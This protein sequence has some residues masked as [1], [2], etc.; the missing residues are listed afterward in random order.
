MSESVSATPAE[1]DVPS[2]YEDISREVIRLRARRKAIARNMESAARIPSLTADMQMDLSALLVA[3][4]EHN[5]ATGADG[6]LSI[7]AFLARAAVAT[8]AEFPSLNA[9]YM[10]SAILQW[11]PVN[12]AVA[13]D[14]PGGL[15]VPVIGDAQTMNVVEIGARVAELAARARDG[16]L[17][18]DDLAGG[19]FTLSN[20]GAV[21]PSLRAEAFLNPPQVA[22]LGL[23]GLKKIPVVITSPDGEEQI[24]VRTVVCPSLTFDHRV[25]DGGE[26]IR[27]LDAMRNRVESWTLRDYTA[28]PATA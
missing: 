7:M 24:A 25:L 9:T 6:K 14:S 16:S 17:G 2:G 8:L 26:V 10:G 28:A 5:T 3:R 15:V 21:G 19:T 20:P 22:L 27:F 4:A 1:S 18:L 12:L 13:V 11:T 23:P